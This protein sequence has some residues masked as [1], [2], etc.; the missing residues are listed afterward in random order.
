MSNTLPKPGGQCRVTL[1][2]GP[3]TVEIVGDAPPTATKAPY[4]RRHHGNGRFAPSR[5]LTKPP[6]LNS[7][8]FIAPITSA[9]TVA[10]VATVSLI[11]YGSSKIMAIKAVREIT[12]LGLKEAK[13]LVNDA[14]SVIKEGVPLPEAEAIKAVLEGVGA[15]A[16][17]QLYH[18]RGNG[19]DTLEHTEAGHGAA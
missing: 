12:G 15:T 17:V 10:P 4:Q 7:A 2:F 3:V 18:P 6:L 8:A 13:D 14:P 9:P 5:P 16:S 11:A 1:K 19:H